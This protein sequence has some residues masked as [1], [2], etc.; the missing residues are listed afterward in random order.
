MGIHAPLRTPRAERLRRLVSAIERINR[1]SG[2]GPGDEGASIGVLGDFRTIRVLGRGGMGIVYEAIQIS[3]NRRVALKIL[4]IVSAD[5]PRRLKRFQVEAQAA[6]CLNHPHIVPVYVVGAEEGVHFFAMQLIDG[7][8]LARIIAR[9]DAPLPAL[10]PNS[11]NKPPKRS[12]TLTNTGS[13]TAM[14]NLP[15]S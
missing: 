10:W 14:S 5:D 13:F 11:A 7:N 3:L 9:E 4:P 15:I 6:A 8:P 2:K 1:L 12:I